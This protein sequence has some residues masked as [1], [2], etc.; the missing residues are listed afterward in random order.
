MR[1]AGSAFGVGGQG[2]LRAPNLTYVDPG[3]VLNAAR[4]ERA[5][6]REGVLRTMQRSAAF[7][8][9]SLQGLPALSN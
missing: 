1:F 6:Q 2:P 9:E 5:A 7:T 8:G 4:A 3:S